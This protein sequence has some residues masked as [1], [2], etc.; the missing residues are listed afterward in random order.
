[1]VEPNDLNELNKLKLNELIQKFEK[2]FTMKGYKP[3]ST[4]NSK[5]WFL[6]DDQA[7][8]SLV[9]NKT[10][11]SSTPKSNSKIIDLILE[12]SSGMDL[13]NLEVPVDKFI[14]RI[15]KMIIDSNVSIQ[16]SEESIKKNDSL[17]KISKINEILSL[18][19]SKVQGK[20]K[21]DFISTLQ[22]SV[23]SLSNFP[24]G[25]YKINLLINTSFDK[26][27]VNDLNESEKKNM[28]ISNPDSVYN[29]FDEKVLSTKS[30]INIPNDT[31][32]VAFRSKVGS[33][34]DGNDFDEYG[35]GIL[36]KEGNDYLLDRRYSGTTLSNF[37]LKLFGK[38][39]TY[40]SKNEYY[41][42]L[43]LSWVDELCDLN[44]EVITKSLNIKV[45][46]GDDKK[47]EGRI[48]ALRFDFEIDPLTRIGILNRIKELISIT[49]DTKVNNQLLIEEILNDYFPELRDAVKNILEKKDENRENC[50]LCIAF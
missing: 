4:F 9:Q 19:N 11:Y 28:V 30:L 45:S 8:Q 29:N 40:E 27:N 21:G 47:D 17:Q 39:D 42:H 16:I 12:L 6:K 44:K 46:G 50:C 18:L 23:S 5:V 2:C 15:S 20:R 1:M 43:V 13:K 38:K 49:V 32:G 25:P 35:F 41:L 22:A 33:N 34:S 36:E 31:N 26:E 7:F 24:S 48:V 3:T 10:L 14:Y 37:K